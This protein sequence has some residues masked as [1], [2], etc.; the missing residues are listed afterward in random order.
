MP[1]AGENVIAVEVLPPPHPG[2]P[3][4][5]SIKGGVGENG[6][7]LAID[8]PTFVATEGWDWIPGIRDRNTGIWLPVEL[9]ATGPVQIGD[10]HVVTDLP[11]PRTDSADV[12]ISVPV[13]N[14]SARPQQVTVRAAF[15]N[16]AVERTVSAP[17]GVTQVKFTPADYR[18]LHVLN[19]R[20]WW[21]NGYGEPALHDLTIQVS[22][23]GALSDTTKLRFGIREVSYDLSLFDSA[24]RLRRVN[25]QPTDGGLK[26]QKLIDV[27][28]F[29]IKQSPARLCGIADA[30]G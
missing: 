27:T 12:Y 5:Q 15:D 13:R 20:L 18:E 4:E 14:G 25:V 17:P 6:G 8:G 26:G 3:H 16:V 23:G 1:V 21:P 29:A 19:P 28:H 2:I 22:A 9:E 11:L 30:G 7:Q 24:G 10:P